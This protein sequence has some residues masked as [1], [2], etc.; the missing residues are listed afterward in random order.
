MSGAL[1]LSIFF[2]SM[3]LE[4][5][6]SDPDL[7]V[8][9]TQALAARSWYQVDNSAIESIFAEMIDDVNY[10]R[11]SVREAIR[12]A[13]NKVSVLMARSRRNNL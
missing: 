13:E 2:Y 3:S 9:A 1:I 10:G 4:Q 5:Q 8:F 6:K 11:A 12:A 7:G